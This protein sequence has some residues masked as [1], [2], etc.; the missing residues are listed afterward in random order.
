MTPLT[1]LIMRFAL[2]KQKVIKEKL[3]EQVLTELLES[4]KKHFKE[5]ATI[6]ELQTGTLPMIKVKSIKN[7]ANIIS[8]F[9]TK[10][11]WDV[12]HLAY[13]LESKE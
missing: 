3:G 4:L 13:K 5:N 6:D 10:K 2:R 8:F 9:V 7:N 11:K 1:I 12:F